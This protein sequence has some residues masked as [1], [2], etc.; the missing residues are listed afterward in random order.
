M[1]ES[2]L[3]KLEHDIL[4]AIRNFTVAA[5]HLESISPDMEM[6]NRLLRASIDQLKGSCKLMKS[7]GSLNLKGR[8]E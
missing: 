1:S 7:A 5:D 6:V 3:D 4:A 8:P 2:A